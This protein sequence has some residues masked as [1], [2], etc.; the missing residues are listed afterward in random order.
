MN[1]AELKE[2]LVQTTIDL[3][4]AGCV[5]DKGGNLSV[6]SVDREDALWITPSQVNKSR[7]DAD[8]MVLVGLDGKKIEGQ[9]KPSMESVYHAGLM[10]LRKDINAVVHSHAPYATAFGVLDFEIPPISPE[11]VLIMN[12]PK[13]PYLTPGSKFLADEI[14]EA[15]GKSEVYGG[16]LCNHGLM[17]VGKDL[18]LAAE[19]TLL[20]E[21][22]LKILFAIKS[23][24]QEPN[25]LL[26]SAI[27]LLGMSS[28]DI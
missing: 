25:K 9:T 26:E 28:D 8:S 10:K 3:Y 4:R 23:T 7:L 21:H 14:C 27:H 1:D 12:Y 5:T 16:F 15:V 19:R 17:T 13:I 24:Q 20:V 18:Q 11:A 22:V 2:Q 6:R